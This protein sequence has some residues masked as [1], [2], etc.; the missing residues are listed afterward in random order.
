MIRPFIEVSSD[1]GENGAVASS[2][3]LSP[4]WQHFRPRMLYA[5]LKT[6]H[7]LSVI[8][9]VGGMVFAQFFLRPALGVLE[10]P[11]RLRLMRVVLGQFFN[12][13]LVAAV[14]SWG[15]GLWMMRRM[16]GQ[17]AQLGVSTPMPLEWLAMA[18]LGTL[19]VLI[20]GYIRMLPYPRLV[21]AVAARDWPAAAAALASIRRWVM[22]NLVLGIATVAVTQLGVT[23]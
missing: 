1:S 10:V 2:K 13:V 6:L 17:T 16:A 19:M 21:A 4:V 7:L 5:T 20:F 22:V 8:V 18:A 3:L 23:G 15:T 14:L 11:Q 9:W 12:A